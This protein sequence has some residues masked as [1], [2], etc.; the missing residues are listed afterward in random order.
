MITRTFDVETDGL[1][2]NLTHIKC[3]NV[4]DNESG[5]EF[6]FTDSEYYDDAWS[7]DRTDVKCPRTGTIRDGLAFLNTSDKICGHNIVG[8]DLPAIKKVYPDWVPT[9]EIMDT[10]AISRLLYTDI[11]DR[12]AEAQRKGKFL[13]DKQYSFKPHS[14]AAWGIRLGG[15]RK[16]DFLPSKFG[17]TWEK[18]PFSKECD[19]Y[20]MQDVVTNVGLVVHMEKRLGE[21]N[22]K[23][24]VA[25]EQQVAAILQ[26]QMDYGW[27][28]NK[29]AALKL[30]AEL[31]I[32]KIALEEGLQD[33]FTD[34]YGKD[35]QP[36]SAKRTMRTFVVSEHG[37]TTRKYKGEEQVGYYS[38]RDAGSQAQK[39]KM[40]HF[41]PGSRDQIASRLKFLYDWHPAEFT[42]SGKA[43]VD[44][45]ILGELPWP[46]A[47][48]CAEYFTVNKKIAQI[49]DG[50]AAQLK[51]VGDDGRMHGY[52]NHN[53]AI[54]GRMSHSGPNVAQT[55]KD[56]RVRAL[57][58]VSPGKK[59]VG[60]DADGLE[61]C[62][63]GHYLSIYDEGAYI[64][65]ILNGSK[66]DGTDLHS[67]N[68]VA[69]GL[70]DRD[71]AKTIFYAWMYG[72]GDYK[73]GTVVYDDWDNEKQARFNA[74]F[75]GKARNTRLSRIGRRA[76]N[77]LVSGIQGMD[78][79][80]SKV[81]DRAKHKGYVRG[82]DGRKVYTRSQHAALNTL[83]QSAGALIMKAA[84]VLL[85]NALQAEGFV[86]GVDYEFVGN[87]HDELQLEVEER[88]AN[89]VG[90]AAENAIRDAGKWFNF[91]CPLSG[92]HAVGDNWSQTH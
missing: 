23:G 60:I 46:E 34:W 76:R 29:E 5:L 71:N 35:G 11:Q 78:S 4:I 85:D 62:C 32:E 2:N 33:V 72:A 51:K 36:T 13:M 38:Y 26:R 18:Y 53:G 9:A 63:L 45:T 10:S 77:A 44:E 50:K 25:L 57:Y 69:V 92:T 56:P 39:V 40:I 86:P 84:L 16:G 52:V 82:L 30:S 31:M 61:G 22:W 65:V 88:H 66:K 15:E 3:L 75:S 54:T 91:R 43:K 59:L 83:L 19:D 89:A 67:R 24:A 20:C 21:W 27:L 37:K 12:D 41:N 1:L 70:S 74:K 79:L 64:D 81:K 17:H 28:Y 8:F 48:K 7:G 49:S 80:I 6:R 42:D 68:R 73:L 58:I 90:F 14:L 55:D 47:A 87:I